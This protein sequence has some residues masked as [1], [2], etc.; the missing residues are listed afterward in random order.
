M[1]KCRLTSW[2][3]C[4]SC[5][6]SYFS[7]GIH[8]LPGQWSAQDW[9]NT[10]NG[11]GAGILTASASTFWI[12]YVATSLLLCLLRVVLGLLR[13]TSSAFSFRHCCRASWRP[14]MCT[15]CAMQSQRTIVYPSA[16]FLGFAVDNPSLGMYFSKG[17]TRTSD[18]QWHVHHTKCRANWVLFWFFSDTRAQTKR[19]FSSLFLSIIREQ[20]GFDSDRWQGT[21]VKSDTHLGIGPNQTLLTGR[22]LHDSRASTSMALPSPKEPSS[23]KEPRLSPL[24]EGRNGPGSWD[25]N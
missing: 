4:W 3:S 5:V 25:V 17:L 18:T 22:D 9:G 10:W 1:C 19:P 13:H 7:C 20:I 21:S 12:L 11:E 16:N 6:S 23:P 8:L 15:S 14:S 24:K 2:N